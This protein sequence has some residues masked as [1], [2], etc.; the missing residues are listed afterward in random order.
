MLATAQ[1]EHRWLQQ[2]VGNW[3]FTQSCLAGP[4]QPPSVSTG[5]ASTRAFGEMWVLTEGEF[6][7]DAGKKERSLI[8]LGYDPAKKA[9]VGTFIASMMNFFWHYEGQLDASGKILTLAAE[10]PS[11]KGDGHAKYEDIIEILDKNTYAFRSRIQNK[12]GSWT[13]FMDAKYVRS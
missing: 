13:Q 2:L 6:E 1:Q 3:T 4:D 7:M 5:S 11:M 10:G 12:D 8:T 9:Y